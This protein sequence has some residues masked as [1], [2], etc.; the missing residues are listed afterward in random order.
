MEVILSDRDIKKF[1]KSGRI[2]VIPKPNFKKQLGSASL[3][4]RLGGEFRFFKHSQK[5]L[6]DSKKKATSEG[7][8]ELIKLKKSQPLILH[9]GEFVL[10]TVEE[11]IKL[12]SN[13]AARIDGRSS[14][15]RLG[16]VVHSTAG[17]VDPGFEGRLTLEISNIGNIPVLLYPGQRIC[18]LVFE[19][20]SSEAEIPYSKKSGAK[21]F[22][23]SSVEG[24]KLE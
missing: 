7:L 15:G 16:I 11:Y 21:Y 14:W 24:S 20:L 8:T 22:G 5:A 4:L 2:K 12:P 1:I 3:D 13:L 19:V 23:Q 9:P 18:Q 10:G 6:I 17:H